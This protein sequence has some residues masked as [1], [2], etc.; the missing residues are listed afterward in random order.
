MEIVYTTSTNE[1]QIGL[2]TRLLEVLGLKA[3]DPI[4]V[5]AGARQVI[6][7]PVRYVADEIAGTIKLTEDQIK[8]VMRLEEFAL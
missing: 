2:P 3:G 4:R 1:G 5:R 8:E 7:A 6:I